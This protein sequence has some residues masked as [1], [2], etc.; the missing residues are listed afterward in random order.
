MCQSKSYLSIHCLGRPQIQ[1]HV[2]NHANC[3]M[4]QLVEL[5]FLGDIIKVIPNVS[6]SKV[7]PGMLNR[8]SLLTRP[9]TPESHSGDLGSFHCE[10]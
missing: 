5:F 10:P 9:S 3:D 7:E 6:V 8:Y 1:A 2:T 4:K